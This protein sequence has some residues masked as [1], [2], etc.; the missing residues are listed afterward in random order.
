MEKERDAKSRE[1]DELLHR[2]H[3]FRGLGRA[4]S[5]RDRAWRDGRAHADAM[6]LARLAA[7]GGGRSRDLG[8]A[9][10]EMIP[11]ATRWR[12]RRH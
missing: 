9:V 3:F 8:D 12:P 2:H 7:P 4:L 10:P 11:P 5:G 6:G 1:G